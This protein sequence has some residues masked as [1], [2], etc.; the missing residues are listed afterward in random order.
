MVCADFTMEKDPD[1][2]ERSELWGLAPII[3]PSYSRSCFLYRVRVPVSHV[4]P[5]QEKTTFL[6]PY[7]R[8]REFSKVHIYST[9]E[10]GQRI[11]PLRAYLV[12][13]M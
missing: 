5:V 13:P 11:H 9:T 3:I 10:C 7:K 8:E 4:T 12:H 1:V 6:V 2:L